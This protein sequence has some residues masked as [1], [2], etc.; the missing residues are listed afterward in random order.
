M[1]LY[2]INKDTGEIEVIEGSVLMVPEFKELID[3]F[4]KSKFPRQGWYYFRLIV[5][6]HSPRSPYNRPNIDDEVKMMRAK[7]RIFEQMITSGAV[8]RATRPKVDDEFFSSPLFTDAVREFKFVDV[9]ATKEE[10]DAVEKA[11]LRNT[12]LMRDTELNLDNTEK[13]NKL[14]ATGQT[15]QNRYEALK[16][17]LFE[18]QKSQDKKKV[19]TGVTL[20]EI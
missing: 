19:G 17:Q 6:L 7:R 8:T 15:L 5:Y 3:Y 14:V 4:R 10:Y 11:Y 18:S 12:K 16:K 2:E 9:D 1:N 13:F 20:S